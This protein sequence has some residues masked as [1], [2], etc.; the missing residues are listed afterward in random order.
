MRPE[1]LIL[2]ARQMADEGLT[3]EATRR[4]MALVTLVSLL[5]V[6]L[7]VCSG[8]L[9]VLGARRRRLRRKPKPP[10]FATPDPW[11]EAARRMKTADDPEQDPEV[12]HG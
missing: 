8:L 4:G 1:S 5:G 10:A 11:T 7:L 9:V 12:P 3:P 6:L 2:I